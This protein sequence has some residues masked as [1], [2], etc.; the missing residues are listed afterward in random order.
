VSGAVTPER[1]AALEVLR[2]VRNGDLGDRALERVAG[3]L[4]AREHGWLQELV[5]G[6]FRLR[7]RLDHIL[8]GRVRSGLA[9]LQPDVLDV[10]RLGAYQLLEM[11]SVPPYA[12]VSQSV[13]LVRA[14]GAGRAA[15]LVNGVL[16]AVQRQRDALAFPDP[17]SDPVGHLVSWGSH[18][19]WL[20]ERWL[21]RWSMDDV[22][23][24]VNADNTRPDLYI[25]PVGIERDEAIRVLG[26]GGVTGEPVPFSARSIRIASA[27][28]AADVLSRVPAIVQDPAATLVADFAAPQAGADVLDLCAAPGGKAVALADAG[29]FVVAADLSRRRLQRVR[30]NASR[31]GLEMGLVQADGRTPPSRPVDLVL[32]DAPVHRDGHAAASP[33]RS[34]VRKRGGTRGSRHAPARA[35]PR[36]GRRRAAGWAPRIFHLFA[37]AGGERAA[38]RR[39]PRRA[40]GLPERPA[41]DR[42][43]PDVLDDRGFLRVLPQ[44]QG[45]DGSFAAR[46][47]RI[48]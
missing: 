8:A 38:G 12:A 19:R 18:P 47:R 44:R 23:S 28:S 46:L 37:G 39:V 5:Y 26:E 11:G 20:V 1:L 41:A 25:R 48:A 35:A 3:R 27:A 4:P 45:V 17:D 40:R 31:L 16:N 43:V 2:S 33:G 36:G 30:E 42:V 10:L 13:E 9:S 22:R 21:T 7:G 6:T 14:A 29:A 34:L 24:L 15:G 32:L